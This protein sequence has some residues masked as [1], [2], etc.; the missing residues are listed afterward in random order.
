MILATNTERW[1]WWDWIGRNT[2]LIRH[3]LWVHVQLT[4]VSVALGVLIALPLSMAAHRRRWL[5]GPIIGTAGVLYTIPSIAAFAVLI[6][7]L[8]ATSATVVIPLVAYTLVIL[9]R[10]FVAGF[11]AVPDDVV[12]AARGMGYTSK[13]R[14]WRLELPLALPA[15]MAG[16]RV[17]TVSTIGLLTIAGA[18]GLGGLGQLIS[19]GLNRPIRTAVTVGGVLSVAVAV[20]ADLMLAGLQRLLTPWAVSSE[21]S[22]RAARRGVV[23][24]SGSVA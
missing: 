3:D 23:E 9:I 21:R 6:P 11:D 1:L 13:A 22:R 17:A 8:G 5:L 4:V 16:V 24:P 18:V 12:D 2:D 15:V 14:L 10:N 7:Y 19:I 20:I